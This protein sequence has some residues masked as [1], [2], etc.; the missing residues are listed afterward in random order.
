MS[1]F[2]DNFLWGGA[3]ADF[4]Y[5]GGFGEGNRG[6]ITAD[7]VTDGNVDTLRQVTY[8]CKDGTL[9]S[10]PLK[11]EIPEGATG[12]IDPEH[13]PS[14]DGVD[15]YHHYKEDISFNGRKRDLIF[16]H[17]VFAEQATFPDR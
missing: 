15:F 10:S 1:R 17:L 5:E 12:Y 14:R 6:L 7:F 2:P 4:Q 9:G 16:Y 3:S 11:A 13:Y 8:K